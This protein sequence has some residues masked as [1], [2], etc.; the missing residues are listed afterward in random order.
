MALFL[1]RGTTAA[2]HRV[3]LVGSGLAFCLAGAL[4]ED[5]AGLHHCHRTILFNYA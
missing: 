3:L 5:L 4:S 1:H 2:S